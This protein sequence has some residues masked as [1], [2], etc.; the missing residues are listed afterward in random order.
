[1]NAIL[2]LPPVRDLHVGF[3]DFASEADAARRHDGFVGFN[4][5]LQTGLKLLEAQTAESIRAVEADVEACIALNELAREEEIPTSYARAVSD[6]R[7][8]YEH[9]TSTRAA[10]A[11]LLR[12]M[13]AAVRRDG[14]EAAARV[15][16]RATRRFMTITNRYLGRLQTLHDDLKT[17]ADRQTVNTIATSRWYRASMAYS[18]ALA[19]VFGGAVSPALGI[20]LIDEVP[21]GVVTAYLP[22][23]VIKD[24][25]ALVEREMQVHAL[26]ELVD[27]ALV[28]RI[29]LEFRPLPHGT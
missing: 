23:E 18:D 8:L 13:A 24:T 29:A 22:N 21:V 9:E 16:E 20:E 12:D 15:V 17:R 14:N 19:R 4:H 26:V 1:M 27:P 25:D 2:E 11:R 10:A 7:R 28:G 3:T 6:L 5:A